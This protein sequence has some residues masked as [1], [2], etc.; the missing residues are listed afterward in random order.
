MDAFVRN[1]GVNGHDPCVS[2]GCFGKRAGDTSECAQRAPFYVST[3]VAGKCLA[4]FLARHQEPAGRSDAVGW[5]CL[6][7]RRGRPAKT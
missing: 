1:P 5:H 2:K 7:P 3:L 4:P 6:G